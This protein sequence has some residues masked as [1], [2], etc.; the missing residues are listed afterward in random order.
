MYCEMAIFF[1]LFTTHVTDEKLLVLVDSSDMSSHGTCLGEDFL[2][3]VTL[4][5]LL[6][7]VN[8]LH[9]VCTT[10]SLRKAFTTE[11]TRVRLFLGMNH[12]MIF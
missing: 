6:F 3:F 1:K 12:V 7:C 2:A 8:R 9:M 10:A 5:L 11:V 4:E